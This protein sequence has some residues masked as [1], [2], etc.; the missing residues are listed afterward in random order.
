[1]KQ[2]NITFEDEEHKNIEDLKKEFNS[3][4][5]DFILAL[6]EYAKDSIKKGNLKRKITKN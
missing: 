1:M 4:W 6:V 2:I 3:N 5:H